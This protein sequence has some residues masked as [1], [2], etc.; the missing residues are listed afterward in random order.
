[1]KSAK[2]LNAPPV[3]PARCGGIFD[4][5]A[6]QQ[7]LAE[8]QELQT[9]PEF[10][11]D[12]E[13]A[14]VVNQELTGLSA[15][16]QQF[17]TVERSVGDLTEL[18]DMIQQDAPGEYSEEVEAIEQELTQLSAVLERLEVESLL[19]GEHDGQPALMT[20]HA[21]AGGVDS[22][23]FAEMLVR[24]YTLWAPREGFALEVT[25]ES[26]G[27]EA[28]ILSL[29]LRFSGRY[30]FGYLRGETG[31]H[32]LVR[33]SPFDKNHRRHTSFASV[34][35]I[36]EIESGTEVEVSEDDLKI[37][38]YRSSGAGGQ[39]VN[40]TNSAVRITHLPTGIVVTCQ[41]ERSQHSNR[42]GALRQLKSK[43]LV[44]LEREHKERIEDLRGVQTDIAWGSQIRNYVLHPYQL[45][46]DLRSGYETGNTQ[47]V[48]DGDLTSIIW[49]NLRWFKRER[50]VNS[51]PN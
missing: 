45:I 16:V 9:T 10:W 24:M 32:R 5:A 25:D 12:A 42:E 1:M 36:P 34:D 50:E 44:L 35:V 3:W 23:D 8:L 29:T 31:V 43:L 30:A 17:A 13:R 33:L 11:N 49:A 37:D 38:V 51:S 46:K 28:G 15:L 20:V 7:R 27:E 2:S 22:C 40:K 6:K 19:D 26:R 14:R 21:G 41:N 48:L 4:I 18:W 39:H 47:R